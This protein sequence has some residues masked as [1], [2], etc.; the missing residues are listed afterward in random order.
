MS[1]K[2]KKSNMILEKGNLKNTSSFL[3]TE[4]QKK[5]GPILWEEIEAKYDSGPKMGID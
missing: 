3:S 2:I 5:D 4:N 1:P